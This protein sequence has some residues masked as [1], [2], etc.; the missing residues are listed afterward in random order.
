MKPKINRFGSVGY[1]RAGADVFT[2]Q[3]G[4]GLPLAGF[5]SPG[6]GATTGMRTPQIL[7]MKEYNVFP[8]GENNLEPNECKEL[9]STNRLL[10]ELIEKQ[11]RMLY[12]QGPTL[13]VQMRKGKEVWREFIANTAIQDWLDS[14]LD[15]GLPDS[16]HS[17]LNK[18]I[19]T[20]YYDEG[21]FSKWRLSLGARIGRMPIAGLEH[22]STL[23]ARFATKAD[24]ARCADFEDK[25]FDTV[26]I[27]S[28]LQTNNN[29]LQIYQ[30]FNYADPYKHKSAISYSKNPSHGEEVYAFNVFFRGI[31]EWIKGSNLTPKYINNFLEN[32]LS[33]R[34]HVIIPSAWVDSKRKMLEEMCSTNFQ[35]K[36]KGETE[37]LVIKFGENNTM[38]VGS[39]FHEGLINEY[40]NKELE[41]LASILSGAGKNQG[42]L[43]STF[44]FTGDDDKEVR[45]RIEEIPQKYKEYIEG[46]TNYDKRADEVMLS[47]KGID[48][49]I[50]NI[51]KDGIISNSGSNALYNYMIYLSN[52]TIPEEVVCHDINFALKLNFP[53]EYRSGIRIGFYRSAVARQQEVSPQDRPINNAE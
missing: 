34:H 15:V 4:S 35:R 37:L 5:S 28:W 24:V 38:E 2:Y 42:K 25:D 11:I 48:S 1:V 16:Y 23:R 52:L 43:F 49:S 26:L 3:V 47:A 17:Y 29:E 36:E 32:A 22:V 10:P 41:K 7:K 44:S 33:A 50:S 39:E 12:G 6:I 31:K 8:F 13:Y 20:F 46:L 9:I 45:W 18:C 27:G 14:W 53:N 51:S 19:R 21:I 40:T 30:R